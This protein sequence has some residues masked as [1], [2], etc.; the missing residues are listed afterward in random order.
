MKDGWPVSAAR[1]DP[2]RVELVRPYEDVEKLIL[3][4]A[5]RCF[6]QDPVGTA[7]TQMGHSRFL[8]VVGIE[9][10]M[11]EDEIAAGP[12]LPADGLERPALVLLLY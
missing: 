6:P 3:D 8:R 1:H 10:E 4:V 2:L 9:D 12:Q 7:R 11:V 5:R